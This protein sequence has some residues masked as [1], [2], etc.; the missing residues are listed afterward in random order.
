VGTMTYT[1]SAHNAEAF[2]YTSCIVGGNL[3]TLTMLAS[4]SSSYAS[5]DTYSV[6]VG[7]NVGTVNVTASGKDAYA[8]ADLY[9]S[10]NMQALNITASGATS[11]AYAYVYQNDGSMTLGGMTM[12]AS[13]VNSNAYLDLDT[14]SGVLATATISATKLGADAS[15]N[16]VGNTFGSIAT[17]TGTAT[18]TIELYLDNTTSAGG[19][20]TGT[21]PGTLY[22]DVIEKSIT[23]LNA[24][25]ETGA[26]T[27][28]VADVTKATTAMSITTGSGADSVMGSKGADTFATG[29][30]ADTIIFSNVDT[31]FTAATSVTAVTDTIASGFAS[32]TDH[33]DFTTAGTSA[34]YSEQILTPAASFSAFVTAADTALNTTVLYYF[35]VVGTDGYLAYDSDAD[36]DIDGIV[37]LTGIVDMSY[38]DIT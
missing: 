11:S 37:K 14:G 16:F 29:A 8:T 17:S 27:F 7:G 12:T 9:V 23:S 3:N 30:G 4:G 13:G 34:N 6:T 18:S 5:F 32:G 24:S 15:M 33:L 20:I 28:V 35:G 36:G 19:T 26:V 10:G 25:S 1:A 22:V 2:L 21:G 31:T 38:T